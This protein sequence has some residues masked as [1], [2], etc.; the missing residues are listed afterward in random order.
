MN[1][2]LFPIADSPWACGLYLHKILVITALEG[3][4]VTKGGGHHRGQH[5]N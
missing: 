3:D 4:V 2:Y 5:L 1:E